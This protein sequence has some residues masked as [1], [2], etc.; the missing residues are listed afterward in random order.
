MK[1]IDSHAFTVRPSDCDFLGHMNIARYIDG[2]SDGGFTLQC[3]W[4][5]TREDMLTG[6]KLAFVVADAHSTCHK[7]LRVGDYVQIRSSLDTIG[8][9]SAQVTHRFY[10]GDTLVFESVFILVLMDLITR[11]STTIP[12]DIRASMAAAHA[13]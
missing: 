12:D 13:D 9:K 8:G 2:C 10:R 6:R 4:G 3:Q 11:S 7:E 1:T 5:L